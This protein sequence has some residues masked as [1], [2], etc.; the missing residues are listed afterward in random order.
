MARKGLPSSSGTCLS[1]SMFITTKSTRKINFPTLMSTSSKIPSG[2]TIDLSAIFKAIA[3]GVSSPKLS[4]FTT[5]NGI[6][7]MLAP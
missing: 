2:Y 3:V 5:D 1:F 6:K 7:L 4:L